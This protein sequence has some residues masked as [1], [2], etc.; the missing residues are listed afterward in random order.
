MLRK[1]S[2][3][4]AIIALATSALVFAPKSASAADSVIVVFDLDR[5][6]AQ[7]K[8]GKDIAKQLEAQIKAVQKKADKSN[9]ELK[10]E[11]DKLQEQR[12]LMAADALQVKVEELRL[13]QV[14]KQQEISAEM[15]SIQAGGNVAGREVK[16]V[17]DAELAG[18]AKKRKA[19][20]VLQRGAAF[21]VNPSV[22][23]TDDV[24]AQI[25]KKITKIKV[26]PVKET[27]A[28]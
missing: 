2:L 16:K 9:A 20:I 15:R 5:A 13:K 19:D 26:T 27:N 14:G 8:V 3:V 11:A 12:S 1:F 17:V 22:D 6:V 21:I 18:V 28:Q 7:S 24:V 23:I 10:A 4:A 25:D